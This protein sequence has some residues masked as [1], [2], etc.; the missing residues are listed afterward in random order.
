MVYDD[1]GVGRSRETADGVVGVRSC[2]GVWKLKGTAPGRPLDNKSG[3]GGGR[4]AIRCDAPPPRGSVA[5]VRGEEGPVRD[6]GI[7]GAL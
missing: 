2:G 3:A 4:V 1:D 5:M 6:R 7:C